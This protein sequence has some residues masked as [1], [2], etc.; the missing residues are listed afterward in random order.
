MV[1][2][3]TT[4]VVVLSIF[5]FGCNRNN[6]DAAKQNYAKNAR[7]KDITICQY[8]DL[9][10]YLP[11]Y[12]AAD[13]KFFEKEGLRVL[14]KNGKDDGDIL[15]A[16]TSGAAQFGVS[17]PT[18]TAMA[19][20]NGNP[21]VI[22]GTIVVG[23]PYYGVTWKDDIKSPAS[24]KSLRDQR[25]A[26]Y[27]RPSMGYALMTNTLKENADTVGGAKIIQGAYGTLLTMLKAGQAD[28]ALV[29]EP[30]ASAADSEG[31]RII[32]SYPETFGS[33]IHTSICVLKSYRDANSE[34]VQG[35]VNALERAAQFAHADNDGAV[36]VARRMFPK[37]GQ[38]VIKSA[39]ERM[40]RDST[41]PGHVTIATEGW[42][43]TVNFHVKTGDLKSPELVNSVL[44]HT[45]SRRAVET[46]KN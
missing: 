31:A 28:V 46:I 26:T 36:R 24:V 22:V 1:V 25:I 37:L 11:L 38:G 41:L 2:G 27:G 29:V 45:F 4:A 23:A 32:L 9:L 8:G 17:D 16:L 6:T 43:N 33:F 40:I 35:V 7:L 30:G 10:I 5:Y 18:I 13:Q 34:V 39:V 14:F 20:E 19:S 44:D 21:A 15:E 3:Y 42:K 12:I